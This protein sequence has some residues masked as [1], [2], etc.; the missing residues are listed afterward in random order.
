[1]GLG[2]PTKPVVLW[3]RG[4]DWDGAAGTPAGRPR[5]SNNEEVEVFCRCAA[6]DG[7]LGIGH[8]LILGLL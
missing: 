6:L 5:Q 8:D 4:G 3:R 7:D 1:M 2:L